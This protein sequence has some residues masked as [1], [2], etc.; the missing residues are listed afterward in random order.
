MPM[1]QLVW[2]VALLIAG[3]LACALAARRCSLLATRAATLPSAGGSDSEFLTVVMAGT[4]APYSEPEPPTAYAEGVP[5]YASEP[6]PP[7]AGAGPPSIVWNSSEASTAVAAP[8]P[9]A[10]R[11]I[12]A[13][14]SAVLDEAT[15]P[16]HTLGLPAATM[17]QRLVAGDSILPIFRVAANPNFARP[18]LIPSSRGCIRRIRQDHLRGFP[19]LL[20]L[21]LRVNNLLS[22]PHQR[23]EGCFPHFRLKHPHGCPLRRRLNLNDRIPMQLGQ[24]HR[25]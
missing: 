12:T 4:A 14:P 5:L 13:L 21:Y 20:L 2:T 17:S 18:L 3:L 1:A 11:L 19:P 9:Q 24:P 23:W 22:Q 7:S 10:Q 8:P 6:Q 16:A 25:H 15:P